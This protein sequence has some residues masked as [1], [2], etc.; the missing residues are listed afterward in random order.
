MGLYYKLWIELCF[1]YLTD[2]TLADLAVFD[3]RL[4][5][6]NVSGLGLQ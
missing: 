2:L 4:S 3:C 5:R 6:Y 1:L